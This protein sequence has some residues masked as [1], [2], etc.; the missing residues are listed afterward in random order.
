ML[1]QTFDQYELIIT[2]DSPDESVALLV[3]REFA[4]DPRVNYIR[5]TSRAGVPGNWN[6]GVQHAS[7]D[8]FGHRRLGIGVAASCGHAIPDR[9]SGPTS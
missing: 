7:A 6:A 3:E 2:D 1:S 4:S 5:N 8:V 9:F